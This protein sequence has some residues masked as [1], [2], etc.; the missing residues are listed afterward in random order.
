M[1]AQQSATA[2]ETRTRHLLAF[3]RQDEHGL[4]AYV[5]D[6]DPYTEARAVLR[7]YDMTIA[8]VDAQLTSVQENIDKMRLNAQN[9]RH[10][11]F[12]CVEHDKPTGLFTK[13]DNSLQNGLVIT[14][15]TPT[16]H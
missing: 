13:D 3:P 5:E 2:T 10:D 12:G 14:R 6:V 4:H 1:G 15:Q 9:A 16:H 8:L 7:Q 11:A